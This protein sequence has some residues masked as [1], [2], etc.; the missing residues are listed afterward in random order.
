M[1]RLLVWALAFLPL[2]AGAQP[3]YDC[4]RAS[5]SVR[6]DGR[7]DQKEW[8]SAVP[9]TDFSD[10]RGDGYAEPKYLTTLRMMWDDANLYVSAV[11]EEPDVR[12]GVTRRDDIVYHDNDFEV[13]L[14][15]YGD[16][17][18]Y[19][20]LEV[21]ALGTVMD[22]LMSKPYSEGG[23]YM[24]T[25][26]FQ[27]LEL[28]VRVDGTLNRSSDTDRG[29]SVEMR[30]PFAALSRGGADPLESRIWRANFSRVEWL[31]KPEENWVW[32]PTGIVDIHH[33]LRWGY[34]RFI[35]AEGNV[36]D[37]LAYKKA[38]ILKSASR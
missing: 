25:W 1:K 17:K 29:W 34:L 31:A 15:P 27:G 24:M 33:P 36:P 11:L 8:A 10:I 4:H 26:D 5:G 6:I 18:L 30:I 38:M 3:V 7:I 12:A 2:M 28:A 35:D 14:N 16:K 21:N 19:Y 13:F 9:R 32:A 22:L 37:L 23:T 20:E